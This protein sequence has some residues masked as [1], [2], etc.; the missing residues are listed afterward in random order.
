MYKIENRNGECIK[1]T[2]TQTNSRE[3][4]K[5]TNGSSTQQDNLAPGGIHKMSIHAAI[6][7]SLITV[8]IWNTMGQDR[9]LQD[10]KLL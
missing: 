2:T 4:S 9:S 6:R 10:T 3:Q 1:E 5:A 8:Y 7:N